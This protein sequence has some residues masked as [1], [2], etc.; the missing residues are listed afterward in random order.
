[1]AIPEYL[2]KI[3]NSKKKE[4][5]HL[6]SH[7]GISYFKEE[8]SK[9]SPFKSIFYAVLA[10]P[11]LQLIAEVKKASPSKGIINNDFEPLS[12]A[13]NYVTK[14]ASLLSVLTEKKYFL[15]HPTYIKHIKKSVSIPIIRKDFIFEPIQVYESRVLGADAILLILS[16]LDDDKAQELLSLA[17]S[18]GLDVIVEVHSEE[19]LKRAL[20]YK[21]IK[22]IGINNRNLNTFVVNTDISINLFES[23]LKEK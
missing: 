18:I 2:Y 23:Y 7:F 12:I 19:E 15:G 22:I 14:G 4:V 8:I 1:M 13:Q 11:G 10:K 6:V 21:D 9:E 16:I 3:I 20:K 5:E 17:T